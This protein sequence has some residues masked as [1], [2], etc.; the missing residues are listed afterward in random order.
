M[1]A[2]I[3]GQPEKDAA[4]QRGAGRRRVHYRACKIR[5]VG[6]KLRFGGR[7]LDITRR[8]VLGRSGNLAMGI[9]VGLPAARAMAG[10]LETEGWFKSLE[11]VP[12][13]ALTLSIPVLFRVPK[14]ICSV[15]GGRKAEVVRRTLEDPIT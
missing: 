7:T 2:A 6:T 3:D 1:E 10:P 8:E 13:Q 12:R 5:F 9:A 15:P 4:W 11:E 14:L